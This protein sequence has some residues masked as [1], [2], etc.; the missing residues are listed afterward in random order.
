M[1]TKKALAKY[2]WLQDYMWKLVDPHKDEFTRKVDE[3]FSGGYFMR[4]LPGVEVTLPLQSCLMM[5]KKD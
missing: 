3:E 5:T 1:D 4:I 2:S